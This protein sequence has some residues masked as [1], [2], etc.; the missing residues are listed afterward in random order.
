[1]KKP[2]QLLSLL[3]LILFGPAAISQTKIKGPVFVPNEQFPNY[4]FNDQFGKTH[5][6][7]K[8]TKRLIV[9]LDK[10]AAH[11][12]N[13]FLATQPA[14]FLEDHHSQLIMDVSAAPGLIQKFFILP[15]L[16]DF[17]YPVLIFRDKD[18]A[19][20]FRMGVNAEKLLEVSLQN[21]KIIKLKEHEVS[22]AAVKA[23]LGE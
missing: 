9:A 6:L 2:A 20:P 13:D 11:A 19:A 5:E 10:E 17:S 8:D 3:L 21:G 18:Q 22:S 4:T 1:M 14:S 15:G 12:V 16:K 7:R 23:M